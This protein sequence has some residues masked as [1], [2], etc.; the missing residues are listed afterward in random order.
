VLLFTL[1][2]W[3]PALLLRKEFHAF[4]YT[5]VKYCED[6]RAKASQQPNCKHTREKYEQCTLHF[7]CTRNIIYSHTSVSS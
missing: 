1:G 2:F 3:P 4:G 7:T 5:V 6:N